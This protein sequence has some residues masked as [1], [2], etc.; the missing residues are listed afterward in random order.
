M[1]AF[2]NYYI[3]SGFAEEFPTNEPCEVFYI[4]I[5]CSKCLRVGMLDADGT[6]DTFLYPMLLSELVTWAQNHEV[7]CTQDPSL[8]YALD[9]IEMFPDECTS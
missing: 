3:D 9:L 6:R 5:Q 7:D 4:S 8:G 2:E 1:A